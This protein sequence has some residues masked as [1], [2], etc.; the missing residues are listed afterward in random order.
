MNHVH[1]SSKYSSWRTPPDLLA[2]VQA[3]Y[4]LA[5]DVCATEGHQVC[6]AYIPPNALVVDWRSEAAGAGYRTDRTFGWM[7]PP[8]GR[9]I[10]VWVQKAAK[11][12][13]DGLG[14][15]C[16]LPAR[17]DTRWWHDYCE[18]VLRGKR[19]GEVVFLRGR[20]KFLDAGGVAKHPA[21]FP[22]VIVVFKVAL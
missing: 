18:P 13:A 16:L 21:P 15:V 19:P 9:G 4:P 5:I 11:T 20:V 2:R 6:P 22:S 14:M 10:G 7:N 17:T 3:E 12:A 8:Y 1:F